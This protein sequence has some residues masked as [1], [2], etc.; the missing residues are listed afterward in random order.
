MNPD[1]EVY[2]NLSVLLEEVEG[3]LQ[4]FVTELEVRHCSGH[5]LFSHP[6]TSLL[7][8]T[9]TPTSIPLLIHVHTHTHTYRACY[10][11]ST[12]MLVLLS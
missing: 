8:I 4:D 9:P 6:P 2:Q 7:Y 12:P 5:D 3:G 11:P 10:Q 1:V